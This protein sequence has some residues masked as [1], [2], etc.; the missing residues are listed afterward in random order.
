[1]DREAWHT[2]V[3][4]VAKS[5]TWLGDWTE[6]NWTFNIRSG[7]LGII[8]SSKQFSNWSKL[9]NHVCSP[10]KRAVKLYFKKEFL[11]QFEWSFKFENDKSPPFFLTCFF[12]FFNI[13]RRLVCMLSCVWLFATPWIEAHQAL[14]SMKFSRQGYWSGFSFDVLEILWEILMSPKTANTIFSLGFS[15]SFLSVPWDNDTIVLFVK[16]SWLPFHATLPDKVQRNFL[17]WTQS[18][19]HLIPFKF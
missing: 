1:M 18:Y 3:H 6:L 2:A 16:K 12:F 17:L 5:R 7:L 13:L 11:R 9:Q 4:G 10:K 8:W 19:W 14:Q 15:D